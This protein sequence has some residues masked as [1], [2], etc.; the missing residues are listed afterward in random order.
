VVGQ[1]IA[2]GSVSAAAYVLIRWQANCARAYARLQH[3]YA[4][5]FPWMRSRSWPQRRM[6]V[7][8]RVIVAMGT[9]A[10]VVFALALWGSLFVGLHA[11]LTGQT[12]GVAV[13]PPQAYPDRTPFEPWLPLSVLFVA[14]GSWLLWKRRHGARFAQWLF[15]TSMPLE[16]P[17]PRGAPGSEH[18]GWVLA[19]TAV[20]AA[21]VSLGIVFAAVGLLEMA[22]TQ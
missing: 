6:Y 17:R 12:S 16:A 10:A 5:M 21:A 8:A 11:T 20:G 9:L 1:A 22:G 3:L 15:D 2:A 7:V 18:S 13:V 4:Q 14:F 19:V